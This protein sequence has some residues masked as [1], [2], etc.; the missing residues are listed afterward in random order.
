[1]FRKIILRAGIIPWGKLIHNLRASFE[2]DLLNGEYG[3]LGIH[4]I[5]KWLGHSV[6]VMLEHYG[7]HKQSDYDQIANACEQIKKKNEPPKPPTGYETIHYVS[8]PMQNVGLTVENTDS[9]SPMGVAQ[10]AHQHTAVWGGIE[11][12]GEELPSCTNLIIA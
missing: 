4:T 6:Q 7:R 12:H 11:G 3:Q 5:A 9:N 2:T 1:M 10:N 8:F